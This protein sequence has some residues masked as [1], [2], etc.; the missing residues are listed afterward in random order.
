M[1]KGKTFLSK[2][3]RTDSSKFLNT[4]LENPALPDYVAQLAPPTL[5]KLIAHVGPEDSGALIVH[6]TDRQLRSVLDETLWGNLTP[7]EIEQLK[8]E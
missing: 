3:V 2:E 8:P 4:L 1:A 7:G 6:A 5:N